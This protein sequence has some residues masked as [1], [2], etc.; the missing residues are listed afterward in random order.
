MFYFL[1]KR[2]IRVALKIYFKNIRIEG[3][4]RIPKDVPLLVTPNHQNA[5]LDAL[6][7]GAFIP[8]NLHFLARQDVFT[9]Y[10][11]SIFKALKMMPVYRI[12]DGYS[13]LKRN[14]AIFNVCTQRFKEK[15][16]VLIFPEGNHGEHHFLRPLTKGAPRIALNA[17]IEMDHCLMV[18]PVGLNYFD[19]HASRSTVFNGIW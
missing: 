17:Q 19:H 12:R 16:S 1:F 4:D 7:V 9:P 11:R 3:L 10:T 5:L 18:L 14:D 13:T 8:V 15:E 2:I 6:L